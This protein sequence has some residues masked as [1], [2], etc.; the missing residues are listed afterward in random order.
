MSGSTWTRGLDGLIR[1]K[2]TLAVIFSSSHIALLF[3]AVKATGWLVLTC[4]KRATTWEAI[5][6][7]VW[8]KKARLP[9]FVLPVGCLLQASVLVLGAN[10]T[11]LEE[12]W[13]MWLLLY[14]LLADCDWERNSSL[15]AWAWL[16]PSQRRWRHHHQFRHHQIWIRCWRILQRRSWAL[17]EMWCRWQQ[18]SKMWEINL[19]PRSSCLW[20]NPKLGRLVCHLSLLIGTFRAACGVVLILEKSWQ[21]AETKARSMEE[22]VSKLQ[23]CL[24][25]KDE[26]LRSSTSSTEQV[27]ISLN[28]PFEFT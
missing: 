28:P 17:G 10:N 22:E 14:S 2:W 6:C 9:S 26:Q 19:L 3:S 20:G 25:E 15:L 27:K 12:L 5:R 13:F 18:N 24:Q 4:V 8:L 11:M 7:L 21:V 23:K 16:C 1:R